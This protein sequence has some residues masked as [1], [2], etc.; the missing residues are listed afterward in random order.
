MTTNVGEVDF[1]AIV[2]HSHKNFRRLAVEIV[3]AAGVKSFVEIGVW[4]GELAQT[5]LS[6]CPA[7]ERY[8]MVD[9]WRTLEAWNK[10]FN[11]SQDIFDN[12]FQQAIS[13]TAFA[14]DRRRVLRGTTSEVIDMI[15]DGSVDAAYIDGDHT[16][17]GVTID[18]I[19][20]W[21]KIR[22]GGL[23]LGDDFAPSI[24]HHGLNYEPTMV[25]PFAAYFAEAVKAPIHAVGCNT[26]AIVKPPK[27]DASGFKFFDHVGKYG[28]RSVLSQLKEARGG[29]AEGQNR[30][31]PSR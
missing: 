15:P 27:H 25:F 8:W 26:F 17:R 7:I 1:S 23:L 11:K 18:T 19:S 14:E 21:P 2:T 16:L 9:P 5:L 29:F 24:W 3:Q 22:P 12:I 4:K 31:A 10:P 6:S 30:V 28:D 20:V 13:S